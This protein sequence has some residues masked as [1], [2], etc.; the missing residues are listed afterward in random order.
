MNTFAKSVIMTVVITCG[1]A[2]LGADSHPSQDTK[3][4]G[5]DP[6]A[7]EVRTLL[8]NCELRIATRSEAEYG[9]RYTELRDVHDRFM[10]YM[11]NALTC[12][13][14]IVALI[15]V[16][17]PVCAAS[18]TK[19]SLR[20]YEKERDK[21]RR[22]IERMEERAAELER[23]V[24][25]SKGEQYFQLARHSFE[26]YKVQRNVNT[27]ENVVRDLAHAI[28]ENVEAKDDWGLKSCI[29]FLNLVLNKPSTND[30]HLPK[31][32]EQ[33]RKVVEQKLKKYVWGFSMID[34]RRVFEQSNVSDDQVR[35]S[36]TNLEKIME[37]FGV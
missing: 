19:S 26:Q 34:V 9:K 20:Q 11:T 12:V 21:I 23:Q 10:N 27:L 18:Q 8:E 1:F 36:I 13:G 16:I 22:D 30:P 5:R 2:V 7:Q 37:R 25:S 14:F 15:G 31:E 24:C 32:L 17:V 35:Y 29:A 33:H 4:I 28:A 3:S 6:I